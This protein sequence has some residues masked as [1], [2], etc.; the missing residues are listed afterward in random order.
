[1]TRLTADEVA[2]RQAYSF[3]KNAARE[4]G[5][6]VSSWMRDHGIIGSSGASQIERHE[7][8]MSVLPERVQDALAD[9][10]DWGDEFPGGDQVASII[11]TGRVRTG[12]M[13]KRRRG[14][15]RKHF[16]ALGEAE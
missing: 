12:D 8:T 6:S 5:Q 3:F 11:S 16:V 10:T 4:A 14:R 9:R 7:V 1:M 2:D 15:P 13:P